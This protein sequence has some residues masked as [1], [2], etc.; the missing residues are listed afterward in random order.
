MPTPGTDSVFDLFG[1]WIISNGVLDR[2]YLQLGLRHRRGIYAP[3]VVLWLMIWQRLQARSTLS[4]AVWHLVQGHGRSLLVDCRRVREG[5]ISAAAGGYCQSIQ[6]MS[7][8]V[9]QAVTRDLVRQLSEQIGE[10]WPGLAGPVYVLDGS[11]LQLPHSR[12]LVSAYP[13]ATN[14]HGGSHWPIL[15]LLVLHDVSSGLALYPCWGAMYGE[16]AESEQKLA[17]RG[18]AQLPPGATVLADRNF[19]VFSIVW[20]ATQRQL[21]VV[22]RL[23]KQRADRLFGGP[24]AEAR[25]TKLA[26]KPSRLDRVQKT[27]WPAETEVAGRLIAARVGRGKSKQWLYL[28]TTL[29]LPA[30]EVVALYGQRWNIETDLRSLKRTV[31]LHQMSARSRAG[32]EKELLT[33]ICAYNFVRAVMCLAARRGRIA[34]R[35]L[36]FMQVLDLVNEAWPRLMNAPTRQAHDE[37]FERVL[38]WAAACKLPRRRKC[39]SYPRAVWLRGG[40]FPTRKTK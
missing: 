39:R 38:D 10:P 22:V 37:E 15:K 12:K 20:E 16:H 34:T 28:F 4:H 27:P 21:G 9:P 13:P 3:A 2:I 29:M 11:S 31:H 18:M 8:L 26:W 24:I 36:S 33:A 35:Q 14:Q 23:T 6:K 5:R 40:H 1:R 25:D 32:V 30:Q 7:K 17:A 19:G